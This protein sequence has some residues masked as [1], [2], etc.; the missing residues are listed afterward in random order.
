MISTRARRL[1]LGTG[2][3]ALA[4]GCSAI[5]L[6]QPPRTVEENPPSRV[7][8]ALRADGDATVLTLTHDG[9]DEVN[10]SYAN[11]TG[12]WPIILARMKDRLEAGAAAQ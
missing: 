1:R 10:Q 12:G 4:L 2:T 6:A 11:A 5:L 8:Y 7:V 3:I 9:F